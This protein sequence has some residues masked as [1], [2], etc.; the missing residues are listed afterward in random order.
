MLT[1]TDEQLDWWVERIPDPPKNPR[2]GRPPEEKRKV[3]RGIF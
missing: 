1:L 3:A 2:V